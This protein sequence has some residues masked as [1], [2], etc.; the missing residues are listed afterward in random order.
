MLSVSSLLFSSQTHKVSEKK[1]QKHFL[2]GPFGHN[3]SIYFHK[4]TAYSVTEEEKNQLI[5]ALILTSWT[6]WSLAPVEEKSVEFIELPLFMYYFA[7]IWLMK[8]QALNSNWWDDD[9]E[10]YL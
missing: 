3:I 7:F 1:A 8:K 4:K 2:P 9:Q 10:M 6:Y 5:S